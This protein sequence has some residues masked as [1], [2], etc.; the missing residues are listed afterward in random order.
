MNNVKNRENIYS[1]LLQEK[2]SSTK[3][4]WDDM[5]C[6]DKS[7]LQSNMFI[8]EINSSQ[9]NNKEHVIEI[10]SESSELLQYRTKDTVPLPSLHDSIE[11][12]ENN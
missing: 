1:F 9:N 6:Q 8:Q 7:Y 4:S 5:I 2:G 10:S 12:K 3:K 11:E